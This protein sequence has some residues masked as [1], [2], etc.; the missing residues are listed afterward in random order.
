MMLKVVSILLFLIATFTSSYANTATVEIA[1]FTGVKVC[2]KY[3]GTD[4][5]EIC[6]V[7]L[8][9]NPNVLI[10]LSAGEGQKKI[11]QSQYGLA[12]T[13]EVTI[14]ENS[15]GFNINLSSYNPKD[16][17]RYVDDLSV[18]VTSIQSMSRILV[19]GSKI[20]QNS[21]CDKYLYPFLYL[22]Q[23][24]IQGDSINLN[25]SEY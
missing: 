24:F 23:P 10:S 5:R 6:S 12:I 11:D 18:T 13:T 1:A 20:C 14:S 8:N 22:G 2:Q 15:S 16:N 7:Q 17:I 3:S 25:N 21:I 19:T 4:N 9:Y